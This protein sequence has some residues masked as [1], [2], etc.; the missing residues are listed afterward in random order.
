MLISTIR[1]LIRFN[2]VEVSR[3]QHVR[4]HLTANFYVDEAISHSADEESL[5]SLDPN[6]KIKL[7]KQDSIIFQSTL[8]SRKAIIEVPTQS[9]VDSLH[10]NS[11]NRRDLS[12]VFNDQDNELDNKKLTNLDSNT[13]NR[14]PYSDN[15]VS[16]KRMLMTQKEKVQ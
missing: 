1:N 3:L 16:N 14:N 2:F 8:T 15:E 7:D 10:E 9:N 4:E 13:V 5:L 12:T 6:E 11:R